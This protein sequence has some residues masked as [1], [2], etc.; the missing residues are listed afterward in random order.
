MYGKKLHFS[1]DHNHI[2]V[3]WF[4]ILSSGIHSEQNDVAYNYMVGNDGVIYEGRGLVQSS[5]AFAWNN[6]SITIGF[7]GKYVTSPPTDDATDVAEI[8]LQ[9]L[10]DKSEYSLTC[11]LTNE[12]K[13]RNKVRG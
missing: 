12:L 7:M 6:K 13:C 3:F 10:V 11:G 4:V 1:V 9:Y 2:C 8:F 5:A